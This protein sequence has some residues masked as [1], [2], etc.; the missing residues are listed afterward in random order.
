VRSYDGE[1]GVLAR[2]CQMGPV[3]AEAQASDFGPVAFKGEGTL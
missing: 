2:H 3:R 1:E